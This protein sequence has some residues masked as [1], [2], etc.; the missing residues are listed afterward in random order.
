MLVISRAGRATSTA[1]YDPAVQKD[2]M[3]L[4]LLFCG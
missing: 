2:V 3:E 1:S 4:F